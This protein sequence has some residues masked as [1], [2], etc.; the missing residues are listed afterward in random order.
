[1]HTFQEVGLQGQEERRSDRGSEERG[2]LVGCGGKQLYHPSHPM[3]PFQDGRIR[4]DCSYPSMSPYG[5]CS[6]CSL[7]PNELTLPVHLS[8][9]SSMVT[10]EAVLGI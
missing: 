3:S 1:M 8:R 6:P 4:L 9:E 10:F 2:P 7:R 5:K